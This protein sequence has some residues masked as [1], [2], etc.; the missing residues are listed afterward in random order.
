MACGSARGAAIKRDRSQEWRRR[1]A[2]RSAAGN[3]YCAQACRRRWA[4]PQEA[5]GDGDGAKPRKPGWRSD[6][7]AR[8]CRVFRRDRDIGACALYCVPLS[9]RTRLVRVVATMCCRLSTRRV[10]ASASPTH[11]S[12]ARAEERRGYF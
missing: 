5:G 2:S 8:Q 6:E 1:R 12:A 11:S 7:A 9:T 4:R 10:I 3:Q